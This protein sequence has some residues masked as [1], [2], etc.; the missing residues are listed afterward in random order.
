MDMPRLRLLSNARHRRPLITLRR[1]TSLHRSSVP[2]MPMTK[3][4]DA[5]TRKAAERLRKREAGLKPLEVWAKPEHHE[6]IKAYA[7]KLDKKPL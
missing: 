5:T 4:K 6:A 3:P 7:R 2:Q 1:Q